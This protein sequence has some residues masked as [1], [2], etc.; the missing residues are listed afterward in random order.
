[1]WDSSHSCCSRTSISLVPASISPRARSR[2]SISSRCFIWS[3]ASPTVATA[4]TPNS[5]RE[6]RLYFRKNSNG[7]DELETGP[8]D[9]VEDDPDE[10]HE[11]D[12]GHEEH[13]PDA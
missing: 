6:S 11:L 5:Y 13:A 12:P 4:K 1:M 10:D 8:D 7:D 3:R 2:S 9:H